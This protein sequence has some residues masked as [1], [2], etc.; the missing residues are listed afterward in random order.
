MGIQLQTPVEAFILREAVAP[1][2][3]SLLME[4]RE[5]FLVVVGCF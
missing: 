5:A 2:P 1:L 4:I 3:I